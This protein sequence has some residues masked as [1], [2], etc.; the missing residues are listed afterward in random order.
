M[1]VDFNWKDLKQFQLTMTLGD[2]LVKNDGEIN[3]TAG[4][5]KYDNGK[6]KI[7]YNAWL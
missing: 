3:A 7:L 5:S 1:I 6:L 4:L 2:K